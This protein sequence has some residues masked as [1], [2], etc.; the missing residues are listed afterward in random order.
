[1]ST[2]LPNKLSDLI[3]LAL[4]DLEAVEQD[5]RYKVDMNNWH[6]PNGECKVCFAGSV[7]AHSLGARRTR[8]I[9]PESFEAHTKVRLYALDYIR[10]GIVCC[11]LND[12]GARPDDLPCC[13]ESTFDA[14]AY[15]T[16]PEAFKT[17]MA[18]T[19][20]ALRQLGL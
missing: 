13:D 11:A 4:G 1:M 14:T 19:A 8:E 9:K 20:E 18:L 7:I 6:R 17:E 10:K 5:K 3:D 12:I 16:D 2:K 15:E